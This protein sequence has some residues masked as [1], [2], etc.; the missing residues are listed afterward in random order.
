MYLG[1]TDTLNR[2]VSTKYDH[3]TLL[4]TFRQNLDP[5]VNRSDEELWNA[6][7]I[8]QLKDVVLAL[9][10]GIGKSP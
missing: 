4:Y 10:E 8:A 5:E 9:P 6:L 3:L 2:G 1:F 7:E